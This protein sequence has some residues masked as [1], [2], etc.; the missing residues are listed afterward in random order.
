MVLSAHEPQ[1][2]LEEEVELTLEKRA[3][4]RHDVLDKG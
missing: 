3:L 4:P 2:D 1:K